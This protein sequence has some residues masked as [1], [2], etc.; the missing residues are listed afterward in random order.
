MSGLGQRAKARL[1]GFG[2]RTAVTASAVEAGALR[3]QLHVPTGRAGP[4][5]PRW[6][7]NP[8]LPAKTQAPP[9]LV[10]TWT[11]PPPSAAQIA[12]IAQIT[13]PIEISAS[14]RPVT[15]TSANRAN[16]G[17]LLSPQRY[18]RRESRAP[19]DDVRPASANC[20][21]C[22]NRQTH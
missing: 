8:V 10:S 11:R 1:E 21:D 17:D 6:D 9:S 3:L 13:K 2:N 12:E 14:E 18:A 15:E 5:A 19:Y 16:A 4:R 7:V 22:A 20:A